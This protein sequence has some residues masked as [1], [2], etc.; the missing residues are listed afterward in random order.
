MKRMMASAAVLLLAGMTG[1]Q[2]GDILVGQGFLNIAQVAKNE[3]WT[4]YY[5]DIKGS[6]ISATNLANVVSVEAKYG[7][8]Y[9][10][11]L[12]AVGQLA[13]YSLQV[14]VNDV[15]ASDDIRNSAINAT[16]AVNLAQFDL[17]GSG[18]HANIGVVQ[19]I[20]FAGQLAVNDVA[21]GGTIKGSPITAVNLGNVVT[22]S[23]KN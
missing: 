16:N 2:A 6:D 7:T 18:A 12:Y 23:T 11:A 8:Q 13:G 17:K 20:G 19:G 21:A 3:V 5:G 1:A 4:G 9:Y 22:V 14:A 15:A 10:P